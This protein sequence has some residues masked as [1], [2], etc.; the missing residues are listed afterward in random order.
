[1]SL[2][3]QEYEKEIDDAARGEEFTKGSS[4][5]VWASIAAAVL[6]TVAV[7]AFIWIGEKPPVASGEIVQAWTHSRHVETSGIDANGE[8][9][10]KQSFDQVLVFA[11]VK[12]TNQSKNP[13][14][15]EDVLA[16]VKLGDGIDSI[17][18]GTAGQYDQVFLAYPEIAAL[19]S[20]ALSPHMSLAPG[21]SADGNFFWA[22]RIGKQEWD[23]RKDLNFTF[24]FQ[25]QPSVVL[26]PHTT[27][28]EQ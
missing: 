10:A 19:H 27:I 21:E 14:V 28:I 16:N 5:L 8:A 1:M 4:H 20:N 18:A 6:V 7:T 22:I 23:S 15:L 2:L 13:L 26:A 24:K 25:Y 17:S 12:L 11:H 3:H 9:M